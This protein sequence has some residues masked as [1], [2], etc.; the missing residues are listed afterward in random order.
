M[1]SASRSSGT[2]PSCLRALPLLHFCV[3]LV[4]K[5]RR[6]AAQRDR[7]RRAL[8]A[9]EH[10]IGHESCALVEVAEQ[11]DHATHATQREHALTDRAMGCACE[12]LGLDH[13]GGAENLRT[14]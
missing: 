10:A 13:G 9:R 8:H 1:L 11:A 2:S 5:A 7:A 4:A 12:T 14:E 3:N 6:H